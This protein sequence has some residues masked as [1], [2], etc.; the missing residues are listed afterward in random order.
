MD[1][2]RQGAYVAAKIS[3]AAAECKYDELTK[4]SVQITRR[5]REAK[6]SN[7]TEMKRNVGRTLETS[8]ASRIVRCRDNTR[9][10]TLHYVTRQ[11]RTHEILLCPS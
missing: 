6:C 5:I 7:E 8:F 2:E 11:M 4:Y 10:K 3:A 9:E 1:V